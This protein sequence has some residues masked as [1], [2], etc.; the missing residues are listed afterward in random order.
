MVKIYLI[1]LFHPTE[2]YTTSSEL[3]VT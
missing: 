3:A 2:F 1:A